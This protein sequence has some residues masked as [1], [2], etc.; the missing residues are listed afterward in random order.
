GRLI[1]EH[2][3]DE[4]DRLT[5]ANKRMIA[6]AKLGD[7]KRF[8]AEL[9]KVSELVPEKPAHLRI[10]SYNAAGAFCDLGLHDAC[11]SITN[12]LIP[13]YYSVLGLKPDDVMM[14]NP[15]KIWPLLKKA[16]EHTDDLKHLADCLDLRAH[17][18]NKMG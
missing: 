14:N 5:L 1:V 4:Y 18:L 10:L 8:S 6:A 2:N 9:E 17:A 12:E 15:D 11:A 16:V 7:V 3:L 13:E